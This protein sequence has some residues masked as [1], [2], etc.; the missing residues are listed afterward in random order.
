MP[1]VKYRCGCS[2]AGDNVASY[3]PIHGYALQDKFDE[4]WKSIENADDVLYASSHYRIAERAWIAAIESTKEKRF[5]CHISS[6]AID[7]IRCD[8]NPFMCPVAKK[9]IQQGKSKTD[10]PYWRPIED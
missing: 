7:S 6:D 2:A 3:C 9:L 1:N 5:G 8:W 10:C 4:W